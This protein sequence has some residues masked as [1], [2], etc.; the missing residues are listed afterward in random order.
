MY[1]KQFI[2]ACEMKSNIS[3]TVI[4]S[5]AKLISGYLRMGV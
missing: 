1:I 3:F 2:F 4:E 5:F